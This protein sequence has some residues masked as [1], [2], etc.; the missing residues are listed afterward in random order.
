MNRRDFFK[1][2]TIAGLGAAIWP[3]LSIGNSTF[4]IKNTAK[5]IIFLVSDGMSAGTLQMADLLRRRKD[6]RNSNWIQ[7]YKDEKITRALMDMSSL[8]SSVTDSAAAASSWGSGFRV[9]NGALNMSPDGVKYTTIFQKFKNAGKLAGCVTTVQIT[10]ATPAG[11]LASNESRGNQPLIAELYLKDKYDV[12]MGGGHEHFDSGKREDGKDMFA[13]F[14]RKGYHVAMDKDGMKK[15][16]QGQPLLGVFHEGGLP[17]AIDHTNSRELSDKIPTLAEMTQKSIDMMKDHPKGFVLQVEAG[18]V[19]WAAHGNDISGILYDQLA[20]DDAIEVAMDFAEKDKN[21][22]VIITTD[23]G[24]GSPALFGGRDADKNF[25][26]LLEFN[27]SAE[28]ILKKL[29]RDQNPGEVVAILKNHTG[30]ELSRQEARGLLEFYEKVDDYNNP[31]TLPFHALA[32]TLEPHINVGWATG[33]HTA[34]FVELAMY[35]PASEGLPPFM[36]NTDLHHY[37]LK[38][39]GV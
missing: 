8:N 29:H 17:Y 2:G 19:D 1:A 20:F 12:L 7:L 35:G 14:R 30:I 33:R 31:L 15:A 28:T 22:L 25:D 38:A 36:M 27:G 10:H 11:F 3:G 18:K 4:E 39:C 5:N 34:E 37:M 9:K 6:G 32:K 24:N 26:K 13:E 16:R 23:H 21:T